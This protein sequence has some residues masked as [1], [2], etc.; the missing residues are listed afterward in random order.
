MEVQS[1]KQTAAVRVNHKTPRTVSQTVLHCPKLKCSPASCSTLTLWITSS[2]L[3]LP[4]PNLCA[5]AST[6]ICSSRT[7]MRGD[8]TDSKEAASKLALTRVTSLLRN[9][10]TACGTALSSVLMLAPSRDACV[11][12]WA[13]LS[14]RLVGQPGANVAV[15]S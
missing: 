3:L 13:L 15:N 2:R 5:I 12:I 4:L 14:C 8:T 9:V 10:T 11:A 7:A 1:S 6:S